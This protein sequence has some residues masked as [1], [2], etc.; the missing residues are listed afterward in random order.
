MKPVLFTSAKALRAVTVSLALSLAAFSSGC[1]DAGPDEE[2]ASDALLDGEEEELDE[3]EDPQAQIIL[4]VDRNENPRKRGG[5]F[6]S[7][8]RVRRTDHSG[9]GSRTVRSGNSGS[10]SSSSGRTV[11]SGSSS[12]SSDRDVS[13]SSSSSVGRTVTIGNGNV[14]RR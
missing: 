4:G 9:S 13:S 6:P 12:S 3:T 11:R 2:E 7:I 14:I 8:G 1:A 10:S 5:G